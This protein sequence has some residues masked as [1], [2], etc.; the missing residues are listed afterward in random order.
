[1]F[2]MWTDMILMK[3]DT[4]LTRI[5][6]FLTWIDK[7]L[8]RIDKFL[9]WIDMLQTW[10]C[11]WTWKGNEL[12]EKGTIRA[13]FCKMAKNK[14]KHKHKH[15]HKHKEKATSM[16]VAELTVKNNMVKRSA[17]D[18]RSFPN[19]KHWWRHN[20]FAYSRSKTTFLSVH[21]ELFFTPKQ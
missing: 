20:L 12:A 17:I 1:M 8:T 7:F 10:I 5:D 9:T 13:F 3:I 14:N 16:T 19:V 11:Y 15:K 21:A 18:L 2:L 6:M 4:F